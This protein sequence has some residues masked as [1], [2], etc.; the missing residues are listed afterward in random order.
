MFNGSKVEAQ[1]EDYAQSANT[2]F[3]FMNKEAFLKSILLNK[4]IVPRYCIENI[5]YLGV[6]TE[7]SKFKEIAVLQKCFCDIPIHKLM[8]N[9]ELNGV[10]EAYEEL[11]NEE[12]FNLARNNTHPDYYGQFAIAFSKKWGEEKKL[13]PVHYLNEKSIFTKEFANT[14]NSILRTEEIGD[15]YANDLL[16][17]LAYI[18][19]LR[20][21]MKRMSKSLDKE[22]VIEIYKNFH[23]EQEWRYVP[24]ESIL[25]ELELSSIIANS[26]I[27]KRPDE[28]MR[29]N[30]IL[31]TSKYKSLWL[32]Y[33]YNEVRYIIVP[34]AHARIS[35]IKTIM[36]IPDEQFNNISEAL[37]EKQI[38]IS[39]ILVLSE[40]R[41]DW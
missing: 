34:D 21:I 14:I 19:P 11:S 35:I 38:L 26:N 37:I 4:A 40:I 7:T 17:R 24:S 31:E 1:Y 10:G 3:H 20:G 5:E 16:N 39:K 33:N 41:K 12:K 18:K 6:A 32:E 23:D 22:S 25:S 28:I 27:V 29:I 8:E 30:C 15:E 2:L 13:Q 9:F 36:E